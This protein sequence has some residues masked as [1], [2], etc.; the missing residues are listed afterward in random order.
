M[1]IYLLLELIILIFLISLV[2]TRD[3]FSPACIMC[4]TYILATVSAIFNIDKWGINLHDNTVNTILFGIVSFVIVSVI[5]SLYY[6]LNKN[7]KEVKKELKFIK[8]HK[9]T[10]LFLIGIQAVCLLIYFYFFIKALGDLSRYDSLNYL[11]RYFRF[12]V[13]IEEDIPMLVNQLMKYSKAMAYICGYIFIHNKFIAIKTK[14]KSKDNFLLISILLFMVNSL[15]TAG[16]FEMMILILALVV[17]WYIVMFYYNEK[18]FT[19]NT[20]MKLI[21]VLLLAILL[22]S[23]SKTIVGRQGDASVLDD[24]TEYFGGSIQIFDVYLQEEQV[25]TKQELFSGILKFLRKL[26]IVESQVI[27][28][29]LATYIESNGLVVGNVYTAFRKMHHDFGVFGIMIFQM[30]QAVIITIYY[31][32]IKN[33]KDINKISIS[34]IFYSA[35]SFSIFLHS[36]SEFF[37]SV[38]LSFNYIA[39]LALIYIIKYVLT[40]IKI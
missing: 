39:F 3:I 32:K 8:Y 18:G 9:K 26:K 5:I 20:F 6:K 4:E 34:I 24:F 12:F 28:T 36:Y 15:L 11:M 17:M 25:P 23:V 40:K 35:I 21:F 7:K 27:D 30:V 14:T 16:R 13:D 38:V 37:F 2:I 33:M 1:N 10:M 29:G 22:F 31:E 19:I